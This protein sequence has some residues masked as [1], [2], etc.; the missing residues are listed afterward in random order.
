MG[1][2][3]QNIVSQCKRF[4]EPIPD[5]ILN[6]PVLRVGLDL[7]LHA[8]Y[9]LDSERGMGFGPTSIPTSAISNY[10]DRHDIVGE[11]AEDM[12]EFIRAMDNAY[13]KLVQPKG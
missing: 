2:I 4:N 3:E 10:G 6:K 9:D 5:R 12:L 1:A 7:F 11:A 13:L 8:F